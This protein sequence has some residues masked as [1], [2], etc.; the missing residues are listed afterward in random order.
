[1]GIVFNRKEKRRKIW[2]SLKSSFNDNKNEFLT[3]AVKIIRATKKNQ[4]I[5]CRIGYVVLFSIL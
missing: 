3:W 1:M 2:Y 4:I 5:L